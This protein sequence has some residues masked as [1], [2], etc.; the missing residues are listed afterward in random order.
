L[1]YDLWN[2]LSRYTQGQ[3]A[4]MIYECVRFKIANLKND[5]A[6]CS[7]AKVKLECIGKESGAF[8]ALLEYFIDF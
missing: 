5:F 3:V 1:I 4:E 2:L 6:N 7:L 8:R